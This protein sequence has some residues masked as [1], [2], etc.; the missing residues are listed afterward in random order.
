MNLL[1]GMNGL[2]ALAAILVVV[3]HLNQHLPTQNLSEGYISA[4]QFV[5]HFSIIVSV[6]FILSGFFRSLSYWKNIDTPEKI[7]Q[8]FPS[9]K[10][11]FIRIAPAYYVMLILSLIV[12]YLLWGKDG[13]NIP[14]FFTGFFFLTWLSP[15]TIFPVLINGPLWFISMDMIGWILTSFVMWGFFQIPKQYKIIYFPI[16]IATVVALHF[17]WI[18]LPWKTGSGIS[19]IWF[20][21]YNPFLFFL[22]FIFGI[23]SAGVVTWLRGK[24]IS[25]H[26]YFDLIFGVSV[27]MLALF[28]WIIRDQN[29]WALSYPNGPYH[30]PW[31]PALISIIVT[32]VPFSRYVGNIL[33]NVFLTFTAKISY[34]LFLT[35]A[36]VM[37]LLDA[38]IFPKDLT[39]NLWMIYCITTV[40]LSY[41]SAW[42]LYRFVEVPCISRKS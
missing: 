2:R 4:H 37:V 3:Y 28:I 35:H 8:F 15:D 23:L 16:I 7:P 21:T 12:T 34:S 11:R 1:S 29:D 9:L 27:I 26:I 32:V 19:S 39:I 22:H 42:L 25:N 20:P 33:D 41:I 14:A 5:E 40:I 36:L 38:Y 24:K 31:I 17:I 30:F 6:F 10:D 13:I 18:S